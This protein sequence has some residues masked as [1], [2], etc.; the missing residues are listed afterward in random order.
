MPGS[1]LPSPRFGSLD[2]YRAC[3][4]D[5]AF[6]APYV[7]E[8]LGRHGLPMSAPTSG[9]VGTCPTFLAGE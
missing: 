1:S 2:A 6:R 8:V 3:L 9:T 5:P 7:A 4:G